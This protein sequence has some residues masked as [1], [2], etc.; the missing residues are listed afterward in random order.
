VFSRLLCRANSVIQSSHSRIRVLI[1]HDF[2][3][4]SPYPQTYVPAI[5][6][7]CGLSHH[8]IMRAEFRGT[9][10]EFHR[11]NVVEYATAIN[12]PAT[13]LYSIVFSF[14]A[15]DGRLSITRRCSLYTLLKPLPG[16][17]TVAHAHPLKTPSFSICF[18]CK[19]AGNTPY[20]PMKSGLSLR[21]FR[22]C[23]ALWEMDNSLTVALDPRKTLLLPLKYQTLLS[24]CPG[25]QMKSSYYG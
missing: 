10:A 23:L 14:D 18:S 21:S 4:F 6:P 9:H 13:Q 17:S 12:Y 7:T 8:F 20:S 16:L 25:I 19:Y 11:E 3:S 15:D 1:S 24:P 2:S 22:R 5:R